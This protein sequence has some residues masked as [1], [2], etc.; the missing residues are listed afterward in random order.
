MTQLQ[1]K[2][3]V[4]LLFCFPFPSLSFVKVQDCDDREGVKQG[5]MMDEAENRLGCVSGTG[6]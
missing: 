3:R 5:E 4:A 2:K 6:R 1:K